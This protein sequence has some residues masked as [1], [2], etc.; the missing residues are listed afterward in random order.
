[1]NWG[2]LAESPASNLYIPV[3]H[4]S[5]PVLTIKNTSRHC[6]MSPRTKLTLVENPCFTRINALSHTT[7]PEDSKP[8][9]MLQCSLMVLLLASHFWA[10]AYALFKPRAS[11][12]WSINQPYYKKKPTS[13]ERAGDPAAVCSPTIVQQRN[14]NPQNHPW[15]QR[16]GNDLVQSVASEKQSC[17]DSYDVF[18]VRIC[19]KN[20][21][22]TLHQVCCPCVKSW[23]KYLNT[24][25]P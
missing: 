11:V 23:M 16:K 4:P 18:R 17:W 13:V 12:Y 24:S 2:G 19:C 7:N 5:I 6:Q 10:P 14:W 3:T 9:K 1:M 8:C 21:I 15:K 22:T 20:H 25:L